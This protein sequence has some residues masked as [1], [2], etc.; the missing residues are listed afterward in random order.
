MVCVDAQFS[1]HI[2]FLANPSYHLLFIDA[3]NVKSQLLHMRQSLA[4]HIFRTRVNSG[5]TQYVAAVT[6]HKYYVQYVI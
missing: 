3:K 5:A 6:H 2:F 4:I 1:M